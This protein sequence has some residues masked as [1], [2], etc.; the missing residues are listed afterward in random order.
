MSMILK[1]VCGMLVILLFSYEVGISDSYIPTNYHKYESTVY[2]EIEDHFPELLTPPIIAALIEH[3]NC[4][5]LKWN[6]CW[7][8]K[9]NFKTKWDNG[10]PREEG[11]GMAMLTRAWRSNG[12]LRFDTLTNLKMK[13]PKELKEMT[14][15]NI[16]DRPDLQIRAMVL[17]WKSNY[18][19]FSNRGLDYWDVVAMS[20]AAYN[21][22][23][24]GVYKDTQICM[25]KKGC[26]HKIW[27]DNVET[28]C[29]K[30]KKVLYGTRSACDINRHHVVDVLENNFIKYIQI[31]DDNGYSGMVE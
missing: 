25:L 24:S 21:G 27:F 10:L 15:S 8:P 7:N 11:A 30:S 16:Y 26:N 19:K 20:D 1:K 17:L 13:Y 4:I 22:G 2:N 28:T 31:W 14:W 23:Y 12:L 18:Q 6:S 5:N 3:E 9:T 29:S